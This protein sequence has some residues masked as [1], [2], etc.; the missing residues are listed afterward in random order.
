MEDSSD[1]SADGDTTAAKTCA[2]CGSRIDTEEWHP[3]VSEWDDADDFHIYAFCS[4]GCREAWA[5]EESAP[6]SEDPSTAS[7]DES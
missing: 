2:V 1:S 6:S 4:S 3:V 7:G 5:D